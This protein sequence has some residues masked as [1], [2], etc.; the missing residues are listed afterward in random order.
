VRQGESFEGSPYYPQVW[1][2][3]IP[4]E[5][6]ALAKGLASDMTPLNILNVLSGILYT[7]VVKMFF[8]PE[9]PV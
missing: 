3:L 2:N 1:P 4:K 5:T 6:E 8:G 7:K 9:K